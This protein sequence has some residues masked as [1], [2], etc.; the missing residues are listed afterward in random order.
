MDLF[1]QD[2][3][4]VTCGQLFT[5]SFIILVSLALSYPCKPIFVKHTYLQ[6][7]LVVQHI[8]ILLLVHKTKASFEGE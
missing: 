3:M 7:V 6:H 1:T 2:G 4:S 5:Y 8:Q